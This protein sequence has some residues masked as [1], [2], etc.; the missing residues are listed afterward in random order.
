MMSSLGRR[1]DTVADG[2]P[3]ADGQHPD[4][5]ASAEPPTPI[6]TNAS[7]TV[8]MK[9]VKGAWSRW[10]KHQKGRLGLRWSPWRTAPTP[11]DRREGDGADFLFF[12]FLAKEAAAAA[13]AEEAWPRRPARRSGQGIGFPFGGPT[14][15]RC[16]RALEASGKLRFG[17]TLAQS[18]RVGRQWFLGRAGASDRCSTPPAQDRLFRR[19]ESCRPIRFHA[20]DLQAAPALPLVGSPPAA[21]AHR[22][23]ADVGFG[24][25][26]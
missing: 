23:H 1:R 10:V 11:P 20:G 13:G 4:P 2:R 3:P 12:R 8:P 15:W 5:S 21:V 6:F 18:R 19:A 7:K 17:L 24:M 14:G 25:G 16:A 22:R 9:W 26:R